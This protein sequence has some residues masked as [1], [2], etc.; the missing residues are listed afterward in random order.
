MIIPLSVRDYRK[1]SYCYLVS[2][3]CP[4]LS[5]PMDCSP[6]SRLLCAWDSPG[7]NTGVGCHALLQGIFPTRAL[8]T[9]LL[10]WQ[11]DSLPLGHLGRPAEKCMC[12]DFTHACVRTHA[13]THPH[14][15]TAC[16]H[17][18]TDQLSLP[19]EDEAFGVPVP[20]LFPPRFLFTFLR[21]CCWLHGVSPKVC[22]CRGP[23]D[24][25]PSEPGSSQA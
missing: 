5:D 1:T 13:H 3:S 18:R 15:Y 11:T 20:L 24:Y 25:G 8:N 6:P 9:C 2:Q 22:S 14:V 7:K 17:L 10:H 19:R 21:F 16:L 12:W 23:C 4:T